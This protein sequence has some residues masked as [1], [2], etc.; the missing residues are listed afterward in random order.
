MREFSWRACPMG[1]AQ[2]LA[3]SCRVMAV[4]VINQ[5]VGSGPLAEAVSI[6][7]MCKRGGERVVEIGRSPRFG[8]PVRSRERMCWFWEDVLVLGEDVLVLYIYIFAVSYI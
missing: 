8:S 4:I 7:T 6:P 2:V 5:A 1:F 3:G